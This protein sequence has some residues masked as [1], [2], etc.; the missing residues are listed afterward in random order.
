MPEVLE[1]EAPKTSVDYHDL[2]GTNGRF[3]PGN[4]GG[5]GRPKGSKSFEKVVSKAAPKLAQSYVK[6]ALK[7]N[8]TLLVDARKV[9]LPLDGETDAGAGRLLVF[10]GTG[11]LPIPSDQPPFLDAETVRSPSLPVAE[12]HVTVPVTVGKTDSYAI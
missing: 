5:P 3:A 10:V 11:A 12:Q 1:A 6:H 2:L 8:A 7:G 9:F 4:R